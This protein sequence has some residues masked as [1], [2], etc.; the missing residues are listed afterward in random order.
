MP[1][2]TPERVPV[3]RRD[4]GDGEGG[5]AV[6]EA[7]DAGCHVDRVVV[8]ADRAQLLEVSARHE[9]AVATAAKH[10]YRSVRLEDAIER[11]V[12]LIGRGETDRV[13]GFGSVDDH[14]G[15]AGVDVEAHPAR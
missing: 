11:G 5:D 1:N 12:E 13:A 10:Q 7:P 14:D 15:D 6:E 9:R 3:Q 2:V 8:R 4:D